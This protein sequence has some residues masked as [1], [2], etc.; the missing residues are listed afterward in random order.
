MRTEEN[1]R[2]ELALRAG[3]DI[4]L[5]QQDLIWDQIKHVSTL[6]IATLAAWFFLTAK[7]EHSYA[8]LMLTFSSFF[9]FIILV[10]I[11]RQALLQEQYRLGIRKVIVAKKTGESGPLN[12]KNFSSIRNGEIIVSAYFL[13]RSIPFIAIIGN[14]TLFLISMQNLLPII[15]EES[16][17]AIVATPILFIVIATTYLTRST[18]ILKKLLVE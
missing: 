17:A 13:A 18:K 6:E 15:Y 12:S 14:I 2:D 3:V 11:R 7:N 16:L 5:K 10:I 8:L 4:F 9:L 1:L